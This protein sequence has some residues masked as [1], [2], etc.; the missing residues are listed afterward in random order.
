MKEYIAQHE[1]L[2]RVPWSIWEDIH[3][4][5]MVARIALALLFD[6]VFIQIDHSIIMSIDPGVPTH[7]EEDY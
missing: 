4:H 7:I 6:L 3:S 5:L 1:I 2:L